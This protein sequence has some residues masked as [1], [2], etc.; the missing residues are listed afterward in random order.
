M[1]WRP[2]SWWRGYQNLARRD[3]TAL[4]A[5]F[6]VYALFYG[7]SLLLPGDSFDISPVYSVVRE[8]PV[9]EPLAGAGMLADAVLLFVCLGWRTSTTFRALVSIGTG[10]GWFFWGVLLVLGGLRVGYFAPGGGWTMI[11]S[12][13][14]MQA[15]AGWVYPGV[16]P[17]LEEPEDWN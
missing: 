16:V 13:L 4:V 7:V 8:L 5:A 10:A 9:S 15:T 3:P 6:S 17:I 2:K 1:P 14:V 11:C 12:L